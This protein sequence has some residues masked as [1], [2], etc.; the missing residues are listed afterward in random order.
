MLT[1][2]VGRFLSAPK[3]LQQVALV[4]FLAVCAPTAMAQTNLITNGNFAISGGS[5]SYQFGTFGPYA[6]SGSAAGESLAG[7]AST[8]YGFVF[9]PTS[10]IATGYYGALSLY[11][12]TTSPS[13]SFNNASP[14]GG[15]FIA[16][17][18]AY[19]TTAV[20][21]TVTGLNVGQNYTL[22]FYWAGA[23]Q[24][25]FTGATTEQWQ[26]TLGASTQS[27]S[28]VAN[29]SQGFTGWMYQTMNFV[30]TSASEQLSF[31]AI[32]TP[33]GVPP[34]ALLSN[35]SLVK[36]PEPAGIATMAIGL[37]GLIGLSWRRRN[38]ARAA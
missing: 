29:A 7:W 8:S 11:S 14:T 23:Q 32:G 31:L 6:P 33:N 36:A 12:T 4:A 38:A 30:A 35:V 27:T 15:N 37:L 2:R 34:F 25:G 3:V 1:Y 16:I 18:S 26:V 19:N 13:S 24:T 5:Q 9:T 21:Q 22:S 17:D 28:V 10:T 20:T